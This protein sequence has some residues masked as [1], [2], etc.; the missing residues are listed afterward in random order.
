MQEESKRGRAGRGIDQGFMVQR[1]AIYLSE[2]LEAPGYTHSHGRV[3]GLLLPD[4]FILQAA[5]VGRTVT[6]DLSDVDATRSVCNSACRCF[7]GFEFPCEF[8]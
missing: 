8:D 5:S 3:S 7:N 2:E 1:W 4:A 6:L